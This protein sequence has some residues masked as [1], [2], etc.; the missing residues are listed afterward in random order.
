LLNEVTSSFHT[1]SSIYFVNRDG[2]GCS[3]GSRTL[4]LR[5]EMSKR[6]QRQKSDWKIG[7]DN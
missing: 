5:Y 3:Y 6:K 7:S 4:L 1:P 2:I